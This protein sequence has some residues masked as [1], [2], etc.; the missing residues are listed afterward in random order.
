MCEM[1]LILE[2]LNW[3]ERSEKDKLNKLRKEGIGEEEIK[4]EMNM[5]KRKNKN[6]MIIN[7]GLR[8]LI[9]GR[10]KG[11]EK[12]KKVGGKEIIRNIVEREKDDWRKMVRRKERMEK[13]RRSKKNEKKGRK[14]KEL[15]RKKGVMND[16]R[17]KKRRKI[18]GWRKEIE[19][20]MKEGVIVKVVIIKKMVERKGLRIENVGG[21][22]LKKRIGKWKKRIDIVEKRIVLISLGKLRINW[23]KRIK[24][25]EKKLMNEWGN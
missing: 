11:F 21:N 2:K 4:I 7:D 15:K 16:G 12:K 25:K 5:L 8:W 14:M 17:E 6:V 3:K 9:N 20:L 1:K 18:G 13:K 10:K 22:E 23:R 24:R 19:K